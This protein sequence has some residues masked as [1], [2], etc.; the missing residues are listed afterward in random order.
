MQLGFRARPWT[1]NAEDILFRHSSQHNMILVQ[2]RE[3]ILKG[4]KDN[5]DDKEILGGYCNGTS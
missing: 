3:G 2:I 4:P 1:W 5:L